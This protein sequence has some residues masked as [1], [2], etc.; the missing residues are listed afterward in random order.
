MNL[1]YLVL[2]SGNVVVSL[3]E[4]RIHFIVQIVGGSPFV[5]QIVSQRIIDDTIMR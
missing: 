4:R 1:F 2:L 3:K 5:C